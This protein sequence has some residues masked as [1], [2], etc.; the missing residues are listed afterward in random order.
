MVESIL[1]LITLT[2]TR[3]ECGKRGLIE[4]KSVDKKGRM[5]KLLGFGD[6]SGHVEV[7]IHTY[8][9]PLAE[10]WDKA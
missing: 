1:S 10:R 6:V 4:T 3:L 9:P 8:L 7:Q 5:T 2:C